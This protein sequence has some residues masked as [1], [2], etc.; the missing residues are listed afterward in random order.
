MYG[1]TFFP[2]EKETFLKLARL[3]SEQSGHII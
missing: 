1:I 2:Y 3:L